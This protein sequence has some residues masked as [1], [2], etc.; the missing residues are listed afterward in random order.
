M[1]HRA[2]DIIQCLLFLLHDLGLP[3]GDSTELVNR[4]RRRANDVL[5]AAHLHVLAGEV[6]VLL[7]RYVVS[8]DVVLFLLIYHDVL[9]ENAIVVL[10]VQVH[11][12]RLVDISNLAF[13][14]V[15]ANFKIAHSRF[16]I[17]QFS[18]D[19]FGVL[20]CF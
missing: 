20:R 19:N 7:K 12:F 4:H 16:C 2:L 14:E 9:V 11:Y 1:I 13:F 3:R 6:L 18:L 10:I 17:F 8:D 5:Y 15:L